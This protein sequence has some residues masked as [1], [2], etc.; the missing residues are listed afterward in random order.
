MFLS[1]FV[2]AKDFPCLALLM[3]ILLLLALIN[4]IAMVILVRVVRG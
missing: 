1:I 2:R 3:S 4:P